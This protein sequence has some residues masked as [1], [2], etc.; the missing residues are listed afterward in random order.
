MGK[1]TEKKV[2]EA[3]G[4]LYDGGGLSL[5]VRKG[6]SKN[7][8]LRIQVDG[9]K[10]EYGLGGWPL[11]SLAEARDAAFELRKAIKR[12]EPPQRR[13]KLDS[14][15]FAALAEAYL[16][17]HEHSWKNAKSAAQWRASLEA[18]AYKVI[19]KKTAQSITKDDMLA[20]LEPIW[21]T[22][23]E[24]ATRV[25]G[26]I[27]KILDYAKTRGLRT[28]ENPARWAG[29][30]ANLLPKPRQVTAVTHHS[31]MDYRAIPEFWRRLEQIGGTGAAALRWTILTAARSG[32]TRGATYDEL[33]SLV[34]IVPAERMKAKKEHR[35]PLTDAALAAIPPRTDE[36][37][38]LLFPAVRGGKLSDMS[39]SAVLKRM[40]LTVTVHG[41]RSTFR[42]WA[43]ESTS[44]P[45]EVIEHA[46]AHQLKDKAEAAYA[47]SD[48]LDK[49]RRLMQDWAAYVTSGSEEKA[50]PNL[51]RFWLSDESEIEITKHA[52]EA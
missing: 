25:R 43:G 14:E 5:Q 38:P 48:L 23:T 24:T 51:S 44:H 50:D 17:V 22:K 10:S 11:V 28:G 42:D 12:G 30:L 34:W 40:G 2:K 1:L 29:H 46:L 9:K 36:K 35:V 13:K 47:R 3:T 16:T 21:K 33:D 45:R 26:R 52:E 49:R 37:N 19:G 20:I 6:G 4:R 7:W 15:L 32:E 41:F 27:E 31:A 18:Y 8:S 39:I